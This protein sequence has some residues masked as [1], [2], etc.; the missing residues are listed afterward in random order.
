MVDVVVLGVAAV[1]VSVFDITCLLPI[2]SASRSLWPTKQTGRPATR[3]SHCLVDTHGQW[4][5]LHPGANASGLL[6]DAY[7]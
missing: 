5:L 1:G 4:L 6:V 7:N 2:S 3:P